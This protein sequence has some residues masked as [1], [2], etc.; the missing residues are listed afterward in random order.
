M[1]LET[2]STTLTELVNSEFISPLI[3]D[4]AIDEMVIAPVCRVESLAGKATA[5]AAF[6]G[7][8]KDTGA[9]LTEASD[10][11]NN[12]LET[13]EAT[14]LTATMVGILREVTDFAVETS[15]VGPSL[16]SFILE[17]GRKLCAE[18]LEDDL[19]AVFTNASNS[20]GTSGVDMSVANFVEAIAKLDTAKARGRM[21]AVLDDQQSLDLRTA[22]AASGATVFANSATGAQ[23]ILNGNPG[24]YKGTLFGVDIFMTNLTDAAGGNVT[25][26]MLIDGAQSPKNAPIGIASL[27][28]FKVKQVSDPATISELVSVSMAYACGEISDFNYV[29]IVTDE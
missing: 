22:V 18:M 7:W 28:D 15:I 24:G 20:V 14:P 1:S 29:K 25:G 8:V 6:P 5:T 9:D 17:D 21:V 16:M 26:A 10:L 4:Y 12:A 19:A 3:L 11:S 2:T 27:W 23:S 13:T